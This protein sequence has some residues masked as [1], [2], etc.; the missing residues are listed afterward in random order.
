M[1]LPQV[2]QWF[3]HACM[4]SIDRHGWVGSPIHAAH[5]V[6]NNPPHTA[7]SVPIHFNKTYHLLQETIST[8]VVIFHR[9]FAERSLVDYE[10]SGRLPVLMTTCLFLAAKARTQTDSV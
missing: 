3:T 8:A 7:H 10:A 5:V 2:D 4:P 6:L 1:R 9:F